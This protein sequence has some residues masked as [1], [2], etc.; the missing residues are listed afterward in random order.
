MFFGIDA[1]GDEGRRHF[2]DA[3]LQFLRL[4]RQRDRVKIDDAI[5]AIVGLLQL[6]EFGDR[7]EIISKMQIARRLHAGKNP[8]NEF[9]HARGTPCDQITYCRATRIVCPQQRANEPMPMVARERQ[10]M[11]RLKSAFLARSP[12]FFSTKRRIDF[13]PLAEPVGRGEAHLVEHAFHHRLQP[14]RADIFDR[15]IDL[16]RDPRH[17]IDRV[18]RKDKL[19]PFGAQKRFI[20][21][22]EAGFGFGE[23]A[24]EIV[25]VQGRE[26]D[27]DRQP[28]LQ[29]GQ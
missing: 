16:H 24:A 11:N 20:L 8:F 22:D 6:D 29:F 9:C 27:P 19:D 17:R 21:L 1:A 15:G 14:P 25:L 28:P 2:P 5:D 23:D 7:A 12:I 3:R 10:R 4:L 18:G 13:D 26:L